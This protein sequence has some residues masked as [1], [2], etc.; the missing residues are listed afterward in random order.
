MTDSCMID[1][2]VK[3]PGEASRPKV[4]MF[5]NYYPNTQT[6]SEPIAVPRPLITGR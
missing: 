6:Y 5:E 3:Y 4:I 1:E 2:C